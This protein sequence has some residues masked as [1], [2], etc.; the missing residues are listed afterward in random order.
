MRVYHV[1]LIILGVWDVEMNNREEICLVQWQTLIT[2]TQKA[3]AGSVQGQPELNRKSQ[4]KL[5]WW[6]STVSSTLKRLSEAGGLLRVQD[7][8]GS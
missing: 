8:T 6:I 3:E 5:A 4:A 2:S 1:L 7:Q